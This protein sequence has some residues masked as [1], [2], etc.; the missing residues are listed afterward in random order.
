MVDDEG[1][2][3]FPVM[4]SDAISSPLAQ[5]ASSSRETS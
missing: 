2:R 1:A 5:L 4:D 3:G